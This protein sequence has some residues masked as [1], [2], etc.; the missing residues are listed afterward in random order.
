M[1]T[2]TWGG[3]RDPRFGHHLQARDADHGD[4]VKLKIV[5]PSRGTPAAP[6]TTTVRRAQRAVERWLATLEPEDPELLES[7]ADDLRRIGELMLTDATES[8]LTEAVRAARA[9]GWAWA[10]IAM[11][12]DTTPH[13]ARHRYR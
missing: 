13:R 8:E 1:V 4:G 12:L 3:H 10:P 9:A 5:M 7:G 6:D 2:T 11:L